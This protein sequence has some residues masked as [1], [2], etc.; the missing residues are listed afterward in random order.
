MAVSEDCMAGLN[1]SSYNRGTNSL[2]TLKE[3]VLGV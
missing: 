2:V 1:D 3:M